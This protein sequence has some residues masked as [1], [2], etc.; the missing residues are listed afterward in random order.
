MLTMYRGHTIALTAGHLWSAEI[1][2]SLSGD[3]LPTM[4]TSL[5]VEGP[6]ICKDRARDLV[7]LYLLGY[8]TPDSA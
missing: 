4:S 8:V 5:L 1:R 6:D 7:D 2:Q 3:M